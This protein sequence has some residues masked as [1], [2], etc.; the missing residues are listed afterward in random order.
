MGFLYLRYTYP[1]YEAKTTIQIQSKNDSP[2]FLQIKD[3]RSK[4]DLAGK[5]EF[6]H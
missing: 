1:V 4:T 3:F 5:I 6:V 2:N